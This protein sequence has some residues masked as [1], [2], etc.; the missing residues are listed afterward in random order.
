MGVYIGP[1]RLPDTYQEVEY[2]Q[3]DG[4][5]YID[6][7]WHPS[8]NYCKVVMEWAVYTWSSSWSV[9]FWMTN[10]SNWYSL[11]TNH[12]TWQV[13]MGSSI[14]INTSK[15]FTS[16]TTGAFS[17]EANGG[18]INM[19]VAWT[20]YTWSY[21]WSVAQS[22]RPM[23][24][25]AFNE[26][27]SATWK[28][29]IKMR[30][31]KVYSDASTLVRDFV[32]CYRKSDSVIWLYDLINDTFYTNQW[33][34]TFT[35]GSDVYT[36]ELKNAYIWEPDPRQPWPHTLA[37]YPLTSV[38]TV[39]NQIAWWTN[40]TNSN[41]V[42][43]LAHGVDCVTISGN[44]TISGHSPAAY[45]YAN[46]TWLPTWAWARTFCFWVYNDNLTRD[47]TSTCN[48]CY[49]FNGRA[50]SNRMVFVAS[51]KDAGGDKYFI[52]QWGQSSGALGTPLRWQ[53]VHNVVSY[54]WTKF[55]W[56]INWE[57]L[58][59]WTYTINTQYTKFSIWGASE[60]QSWNAFNGS[61]SWVIVENVART[62]EE[63]KHHYNISRPAYQ[64]A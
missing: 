36:N 33:S 9:F 8:S 38:T 1:Q 15:T 4:N 6:T 55:D 57:L 17:L 45:L 54:S 63:A 51:G 11:H 41:G 28:A 52:S 16:W 21:S 19:S 44:N 56:Y 32:P 40:L 60:N 25:F 34:W 39:N 2:I 14:N 13:N 10:W 37:Y 20:T 53:W 59:S 61:F 5:Q 58:W 46:I 30:S 27:W 24:I 26:S 29:T 50:S 3:S 35:K 18:S 43:W 22:T 49:V 42:F 12:S 23:Y 7:W 64:T 62:A 48:E 47:D 31:F